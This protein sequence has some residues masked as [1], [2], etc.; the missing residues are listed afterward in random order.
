MDNN[1]DVLEKFRLTD[2]LYGYQDEN[3]EFIKEESG[4]DM[5]KERL[6][7]QIVVTVTH[8]VPDNIAIAAYW[9][10]RCVVHTIDKFEM[11]KKEH[12]IKKSLVTL[13]YKLKDLS[14]VINN[15]QES[16]HC[17]VYWMKIIDAADKGMGS[18]P[19]HRFT[20]SYKLLQES[21]Y[22]RILD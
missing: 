8:E 20:D 2:V 1:S 16:I 19:E 5:Q 4:V 9:L 11:F 14:S 17:R 21:D 6:E 10:E 13:E 18:E 3:I 15:V 7:N 22:C 12:S